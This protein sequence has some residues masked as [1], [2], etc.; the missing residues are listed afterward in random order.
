M[1][2][3]YTYNI[4]AQTDGQTGIVSDPILLV[5]SQSKRTVYQAVEVKTMLPHRLPSPSSSRCMPFAL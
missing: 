5:D 1:D 2:W 4:L 3:P